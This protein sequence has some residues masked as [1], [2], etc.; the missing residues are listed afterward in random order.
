VIWDKEARSVT[1]ALSAKR[2]DRV[3]VGGGSEGDGQAVFH[4]V[5]NSINILV[6]YSWFFL[7]FRF[8]FHSPSLHAVEGCLMNSITLYFITCA[9][10]MGFFGYDS[11]GPAAVSHVMLDN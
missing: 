10:G 3:G 4:S 8:F 7:F 5:S 2:R 6:S 1:A 9:H 11:R